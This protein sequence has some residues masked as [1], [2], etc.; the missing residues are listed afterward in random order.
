MELQ[1]QLNR[2]AAVKGYAKIGV[3]GLLGSKTIVLYNKVMGTSVNGL[4]VLSMAILAAGSGV[5]AKARMLADGA[6]APATVSAPPSKYR[7]PSVNANGSV[8]SSQGPASMIPDGV[9]D[10]FTSPLGLVAMAGL[11]YVGYRY[12]KGKKAP[13]TPTTAP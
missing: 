2:T 5:I 6:K 13:S 7:T 3:D 11:G 4:D 9:F 10:L 12:Y 1:Y 8:N